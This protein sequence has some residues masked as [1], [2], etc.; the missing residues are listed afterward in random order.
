MVRKKNNCKK[1]KDTN[2]KIFSHNWIFCSVGKI[3]ATEQRARNGFIF[4]LSDIYT[5]NQGSI[6][7]LLMNSFFIVFTL[8]SALL[9]DLRVINLFFERYLDSVPEICI[10]SAY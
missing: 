10:F 3:V 1:G 4:R 6:D 5:Q 7:N 8:M 2:R 9:A